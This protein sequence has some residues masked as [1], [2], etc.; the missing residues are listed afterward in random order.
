MAF[1]SEL[2][3]VKH[4]FTK[5]RPVMMDLHPTLACQNKCYFCVSENVNVTG[6]EHPNFDRKKSI[7]WEDLKRVIREWK[8]MGIKSVQLTGGGE[9]TLYGNFA[10][11]MAELNGNFKVGLITNGILLEKYPKE[12]LQTC[13]WVRVSL[14]AASFGTY[15]NIKGTGHFNTVIDGLVSLL[16]SK[17][18][19]NEDTRIGVAFIIT[20]E[21]I[22]DIERLP[23]ILDN[24]TDNGRLLMPNYI[25]YKDVI[26]RYTEFNADTRAKIDAEI[27]KARQRMPS[28]TQCYYTK[29]YGVKEE[30]LDFS[31][32]HILDYVGVL[33]ADGN[34][35]GCCHREYIPESS[36]GSIYNQSF[37][38]IWEH[39]KKLSIEQNLCFNCRFG[40]SN[41]LLEKLNGIEDEDFL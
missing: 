14:D 27:Q 12:I 30:Y 32:C 21:N 38:E 17:K 41:A 33:G 4:Y 18:S 31:A 24:L 22:S 16:E 6:V 20:P 8:D 29:H 3:I 15:K 36:Y 10:D 9:P 2:K 11:L 35:Y 28:G 1:M 40:K 13:D 23:F 34:V 19:L 7:P 5:S 37:K 26:N 25:Q 39:K